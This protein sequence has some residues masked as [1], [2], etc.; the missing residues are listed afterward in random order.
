MTHTAAAVT[1]DAR[2]WAIDLK[3]VQK[4]YKGKVHALQGIDMRVRRGEV[5]GL[6]GPNGAGKSTL[7]KIMM[8]VIRPTH[9]DGTILGHPVGH[10]PTL[11]QVGYLPEQHRFPKYLTGRQTLEFFGALSKVD[12]ATAKKRAGELLSTVGMS[13]WG[14]KKVS[15]YSKG[16]MQ[17]VGLAQTLMSD[18]ELVVLDEPTDGVDPVGRRDIRDVLNRLREQGKTVFVNSHLL[19]ELEMI[20][21]RVAILVRGRVVKQGTID[22]LTRAQ[23]RY[24][25]ELAETDP[26]AMAALRPR[27]LE[28]IRKTGAAIAEKTPAPPAPPAPPPLPSPPVMGFVGYVPVFGV[29]ANGPQFA[30]DAG[31]LGNGKW[32]E[33]EGPVIRI[34]TTDP[35]EIQPVLDALRAAGLV[36]R[37]FNPV[38]QTLEALFM[39][40]VIDPASGQALPP[41]AQRPTHGPPGYGYG[42]PVGAPPAPAWPGAGPPQPGPPMAPAGGRGP[43]AG[44]AA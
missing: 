21:E 24:D 14:D 22:D 19:Q 29:H 13:D 2:D 30:V 36:I 10:K 38:R 37:R 44:G 7:V 18:P 35:A 26:A 3:N 17:R 32:V 28:A 4:V 43:W 9:A 6:L 23:Q 33:L 31:T 39:E 1:A 25:I 42:F 12:R 41:G 20:C 34:G 27:V 8:T 15:T 40:A 16:M 5:F 11:R